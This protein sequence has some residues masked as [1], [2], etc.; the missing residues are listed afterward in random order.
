MVAAK[1]K[2]LTGPGAYDISILRGGSLFGRVMEIRLFIK[3][4]VAYLCLSI[5]QVLNVKLLLG[6]PV[7]TQGS[8][9]SP[10]PARIIGD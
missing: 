8:T 1:S 7:A 10:A 3:L 6:L 5:L 2:G 9:S 4:Y